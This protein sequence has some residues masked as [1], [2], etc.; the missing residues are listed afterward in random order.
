MCGPS[1]TNFVM[2]R[3]YAQN[4]LEGLFKHLLYS[5]WFQEELFFNLFIDHIR[6]CFDQNSI[7]IAQLKRMLLVVRGIDASPL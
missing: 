1:I 4:G 3:K 7:K 6:C 2:S 5:C